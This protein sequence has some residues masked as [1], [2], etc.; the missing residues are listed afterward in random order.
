[1]RDVST[2]WPATSLRLTIPQTESHE[3]AWMAA[4]LSVTYWACAAL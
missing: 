3:S 4:S 1:M 2:V